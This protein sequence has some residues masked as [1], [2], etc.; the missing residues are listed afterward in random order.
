MYSLT[1]LAICSTR[2]DGGMASKLKDDSGSFLN[3]TPNQ[4]VKSYFSI[5]D[6]PKIEK[7]ELHLIMVSIPIK[8]SSKRRAGLMSVRSYCKPEKRL[9]AETSH[10][11][12]RSQISG[13]V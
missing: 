2:E 3:W 10:Q 4:I 6:L 7:I 11:E 12:S 1:T 8:V 5:V 9:E 13:C